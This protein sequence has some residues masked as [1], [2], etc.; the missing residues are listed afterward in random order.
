[1]GNYQEY[2][3]K[4]VS[5]VEEMEEIDEEDIWRRKF[6]PPETEPL[7]QNPDIVGLKWRPSMPERLLRTVI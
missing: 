7:R 5:L 1:M 2:D 4:P 3:D 6:D